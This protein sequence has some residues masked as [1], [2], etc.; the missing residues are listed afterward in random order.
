M[1]S[2]A[3]GV[4]WYIA[5]EDETYKFMLKKLF[6]VLIIIGAGFTTSFS[7]EMETV[8]SAPA[9]WRAELIPF[10]LEFAPEIDFT[11]FVDV[12]FAPGWSDLNSK[13]FW[14]YSFVW[15]IDAVANMTEEELANL[16]STYYDGLMSSVLKSQGDSTNLNKLE[17]TLS[18]FVKTETG[19]VGKVR[20]FDPFFT[21]QSI[22]LNIM[23]EE[24]F[25][26]A[27]NKQTIAF[28]LSPKPIDDGV[29]SEFEKIRLVAKCN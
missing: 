24:S 29:W 15:H 16:F 17:K 22:T 14:T 10:P 19:F 21:K 27:T 28:D 9:G 8:L 20:M 5:S 13:Q 12:R 11:G 7:Q 6:I 23:V 4:N 26:R 3:V 2:Y 18:L 1:L 25:C